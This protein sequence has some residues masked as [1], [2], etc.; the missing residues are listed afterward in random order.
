M[1]TDEE[2]KSKCLHLK[3]KMIS[4]F[5]LDLEKSSANFIKRFAMK[6]FYMTVR[7]FFNRNS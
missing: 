3:A 6:K 4:N 1:S 7:T 2:F 5:Q